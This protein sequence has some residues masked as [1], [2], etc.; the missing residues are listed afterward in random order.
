M[1]FGKLIISVRQGS[2]SLPI[3]NCRVRIDGPDGVLLFETE[4]IYPLPGDEVRIETPPIALSLNEANTVI[5]YSTC[6]VHIRAE[7]HFRLGIFGVQLFEDRTASLTAELVPL[8]SGDDSPESE[9]E[10]RID[11]P[12]HQLFESAGGRTPYP[13]EAST[14]FL[15]YEPAVPAVTSPNVFVPESV[16][17]HMGAP[18]ADAENITVSFLDYLKNVACSEIYP[19][20]PEESLR[21]NIIAQCSIILN[22]VYTEWYRSRGY[23][24]DITNDTAYDQSFVNGRNIFSNISD[25]VDSLF[26]TFIT[27]PGSVEPLFAQYCN[28]TTSTC[29]GLSQWGTV[30]LA[31]SGLS[32]REIL[33]FYFGD[34]VISETDDIRSSEGSFPGY[35]LRPGSR[36]SDVLLIQEKLNRIAINFPEIPLNNTTGVY[37]EYTRLA[38][39][40]FQRLFLLPVTGNTDK[41]T[42]YRI[43]SIYASVKR[44]AE[45]TSEGLRASY[46]SQLYPGKPLEN[47]SKGSEVQEIQFYLY[48]ISFFNN[49]V[50]APRIDGIYGSNTRD[51]VI[52]FQKA[53]N[54]SQTGIVDEETWNKIVAVYNGSKENIDAPLATQQTEP[55]DGAPLYRGDRD[56]RV[57]YI[58]TALNEIQNVFVIIPEQVANGIF[59]AV[60]ENAVKLFSQLFGLPQN[61]Y[62]DET[63]WNKVNQL[64]VAVSSGCVFANSASAGTQPYPGSEI[65]QGDS[66]NNV[67]YIQE[68]INRIY[69]SIP[70]V[71]SLDVDGVFGSSTQASVDTLRYV[72]GLTQGGSVDETTWLLINYIFSAVENGCLPLS[73]AETTVFAYSSGISA[74]DLKELMRKNGIRVS[75]MPHFGLASK[76]A[77]MRWQSENGLLPTGE[78]DNETLRIL[79]RKMR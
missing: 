15:E 72:F 40:V 61:G 29:A 23:D 34:I 8:P 55:W 32:Y 70:Y 73:G 22:R 79:L 46:N 57:E 48:R 78:P 43:G 13:P 10:L 51:A 71:G 39:E 74:K 7:N 59:G 14:A 69:D 66:G 54:L 37:D 28:G 44:L 67:R 36:G 17:V 5:P 20:W 75:S 16:T 18:D 52:S 31:N 19:T 1:P 4:I 50:T 9:P 42:W 33:E 60:T 68:K 30:S 25:I 41:A 3:K 76:R 11:I 2:D 77:L 21:A 56:R 35:T 38:V 45:I 12:E 26:N 58:Q 24:F 62:I 64:Y 53:Y 47:S 27:R 49:A 65:A 6:N 63:L